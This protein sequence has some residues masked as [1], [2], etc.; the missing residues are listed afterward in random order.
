MLLAEDILLLVLDDTSGRF[1]L[2]SSYVNPLVAGALLTDLV[3]A[4]VARITEKGETIRA[5][6]VVVEPDA[7]LADPLLREGLARLSG[8]PSWRPVAAL[9]KLQKG[10]RQELIDRLVRAERLYRNDAQLLGF[11]PVKRWPA[12][13]ASY[14]A[15]LL[16]RMDA[17]SLRGEE[18]DEHTASLIGLLSA[19]N[20][21]TKVL[22]RDGRTFDKRMVK[23]RAK[24]LREQ[25]WTAK[26]V[27]RAIEEIQAAG[28]AAAAG[29]AGG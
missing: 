26:A 8:R 1:L 23:R 25:R 16:A 15:E 6:R 4:R 22:G 21:I 3:D 5:N 10:L 18:P 9:Q 7:E 12:V 13:E 28:A 17:V 14:E 19:A 11:I 2:Q 29:G 20:V 24:D 27:G